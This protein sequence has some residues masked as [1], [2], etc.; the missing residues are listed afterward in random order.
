MF[1]LQLLWYLIASKFL[2]GSMTK[3]KRPTNSNT[4]ATDHHESFLHFNVLYYLLLSTFYVAFL[5]TKYT[6]I[7][8]TPSKKY[9]FRQIQNWGQIKVFVVVALAAFIRFILFISGH[10][11]EDMASLFQFILSLLYTVRKFD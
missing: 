8:N 1:F 9:S 3:L 2:I 4:T 11:F 6:E 7:R 10:Q 5:C